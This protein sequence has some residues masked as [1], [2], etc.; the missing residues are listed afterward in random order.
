MNAPGR[1]CCAAGIGASLAAAGY[2][3]IFLTAIHLTPNQ[4]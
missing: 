2:L 4:A 3:Y 1:L